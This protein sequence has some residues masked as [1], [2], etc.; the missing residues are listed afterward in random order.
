MRVEL[1]FKFN[2]PVA[3]ASFQANPRQICRSLPATR[4][5]GYAWIWRVHSCF[6]NL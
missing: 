3:G 1:G 4:S 6:E 5:R 2:G